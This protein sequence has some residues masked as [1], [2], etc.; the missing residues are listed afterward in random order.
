MHRIKNGEQSGLSELEFAAA[1]VRLGIAPSL[2]PELEGK[3]LD[4]RFIYDGRDVFAEVIAPERSDAMMEAASMISDLASLLSQENRGAEIEVLL[5]PGID[6]TRLREVAEYIRSVPSSP[7]QREISGLAT[8]TKTSPPV[9]FVVSPRIAH[10]DS[11]PVLGCARGLVENGVPAALA[12]VR[13][14]IDDLRAQQMLAAELHHF[15]K[16]HCNLL[17]MNLA[18]VIGG[19]KSWES[20]LERCFQPDRNTRI[21]AVILY[22]GGLEGGAAYLQQWKSIPNRYAHAPIPALLLKALASLDQGHIS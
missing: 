19:I 11:T 9:S 17:V 21:G 6:P 7:E 18:Q 15:S 12:A 1:L 14:P 16:E 13:L 4:A 22:Q 8:F 3:M 20:L 5:A 10:R 2:E